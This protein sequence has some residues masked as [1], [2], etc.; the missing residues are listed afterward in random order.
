MLITYHRRLQHGT[1]GIQG[2][3]RRI[4]TLRSKTTA[5]HSGGIKVGKSGGWCRI[6][7]VVGRDV[8]GLN[9]RNGTFESGGD[10][11]L[12]FANVSTKSWLVSHGRRHASQQGAYFRT[13][14]DKAKDVVNK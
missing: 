1:G 7:K 5:Q 3:N 14:L 9:R 4:D 11:L 10:T 12:Q 6:G 2:V 8:D 13:G